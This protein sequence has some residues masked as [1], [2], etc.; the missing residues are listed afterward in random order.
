MQLRN[1]NNNETY[2]VIGPVYEND[3]T[4][5]WCGKIADGEFKGAFVKMLNYGEHEDK[6]T[7]FELKNILQEE[8]NTLRQVSKCSKK[9]PG[10][11]TSWNDTKRN[12]YV[13]IMDTMPG[14]SLRDWLSKH[15]KAELQAKDI[16]I[17]KCMAVQICEIMRD[18]SKKYP[19]LVHRDLKPENIFVNFNNNTKKW[20][21]Y[22]IDF[23][24]AN[25]NYIRNLGTT[26]YQAPEQLGIRNTRVSI[27]S[28]TDIFAIGQVMYE[29]LLGRVPI[30][31]EDYQYKAR[32]N[33]WVQVPQL[34]E[35][36]D[37]ISGLSNLVELINKM[38]GFEIDDRPSYET[39]IR[40]L[41]NIRIG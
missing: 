26:N 37:N 14:V 11:K 3:T 1:C 13:V 6:K 5:I 30:V 23:G 35:Y 25:L 19:V 10:V 4:K 2:E 31:G 15:Q 24:C 40:N 39:I 28:K 20:D 33:S 36:L 17:R 21:V 16:F 8:I 41:K 34:P 32:Q 12:R 9:V 27:T 7:A 22:I 29:M 18:I 38:T